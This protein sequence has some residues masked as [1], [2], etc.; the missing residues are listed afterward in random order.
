[1]DVKNE[2]QEQIQDVE[3]RLSKEIQEVEEILIVHEKRI[4]ALEQV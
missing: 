2:L 4:S 1:M 3:T